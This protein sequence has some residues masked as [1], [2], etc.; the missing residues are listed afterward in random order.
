[1]T[2][3]ATSAIL[4]ALAVAVGWT[5]WS[6]VVPREPSESALPAGTAVAEA[7]LPAVPAAAAPTLPAR[8]RPVD[9]AGSANVSSAAP[10][11]AAPP[12]RDGL[13]MEHGMPTALHALAPDIDVQAL[14]PPAAGLPPGI[15]PEDAVVNR[16]GTVALTRSAD[17]PAGGDASTAN[18]SRPPVA[19]HAP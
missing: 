17:T 14:P 2:R 8:P 7:T 18:A 19:T 16:A 12:L 3:M 10:R 15:Q 13:V 11:Q 1:M 4:G 5:V 9:Q 6:T